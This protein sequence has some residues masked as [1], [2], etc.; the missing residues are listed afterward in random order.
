MEKPE[1]IRKEAMATPPMIQPYRGIPK[2]APVI[3]L[4][5]FHQENPIFL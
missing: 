2:K 3:D 4:P 5:P 1:F